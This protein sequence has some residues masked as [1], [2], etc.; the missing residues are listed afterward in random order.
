MLTR[1][2]D[3]QRVHTNGPLLADNG[4][5]LA[6]AAEAGMGIALLPHFIV[7]ESLQAGRL[8]TVLPE[9]QAPLIYVSVVFASA[10][11]LP[12]KTRRFIDFLVDELGDATP[13][14]QTAR[15]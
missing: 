1:G 11:R 9:W 14:A 6:L 3:V 2:R 10:R 5:V 13:S 7:E 4:D 15:R 12:L 8:V